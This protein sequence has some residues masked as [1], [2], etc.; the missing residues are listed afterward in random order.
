[1]SV[2]VLG[3]PFQVVPVVWVVGT[4]GVDTDN[5]EDAGLRRYGS[6][7]SPACSSSCGQYQGAGGT[8]SSPGVLWHQMLR[9]PQVDMV[10][11]R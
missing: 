6:R 2:W 1:M 10:V 9:E 4:H 8:G 11:L 5:E 7:I 3:D